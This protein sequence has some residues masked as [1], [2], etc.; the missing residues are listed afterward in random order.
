MSR[1]HRPRPARAPAVRPP[2]GARGLPRGALALRG[3]H[4]DVH[5]AARGARRASTAIASRRGSRSRSARRSSAMLADRAAAEPLPPPPRPPGRARRE[6]GAA[7]A[8]A[9]PRFHR[10]AEMYLAR[11]YRARAR[12]PRRVAAGPDRAP[13]APIASAGVIDLITSRGDARPPAAPRAPSPAAVRAQIEVAA[14]EYRRFFG[15]RAATASGCPSARTSPG[16]DAELARAGVRYFFV[17]THGIAHASPRPVYG[18]YAP[19]ACESGVAAFGRDPDSSKQVWSARRGLPRRSLVPRLLPRHRL[20]P[21]LRVRAPLPAADR[22]ARPHRASSTTGSPGRPTRRSPTSPTGPASAGRRR[23]RAHFVDARL[24]QVEWLGAHDGPRRRSSSA[25]TTPSSSATGGSRAR[26][27]SSVVLRR[28]GAT[29]GLTAPRRRATTSDAQPAVQRATPAASTWGMRRAT[30]RS[31]SAAGTTGYTG[32]CT[33]P[34]DRLHAPLPALP[35]R[36]RAHAARA[37]P[38]A[39]RAAPRAGERLGLHDVARDD[40]ASTPTRRT[41]DHLLRCQ[42]LCTEVERDAVDDLRLAALEDADNIF[43]TLD[44][45]VLHCNGALVSLGRFP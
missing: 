14:A 43:P 8:S 35:E 17:D 29:P 38:G 16:I 24:R 13:S 15:R 45:R 28:L 36:R 20:R 25:P 32:T 41:R 22:A 3:D 11:F 39:A 42:R 4:R 2:S 18:V 26:S 23:T 31:G 1:R 6:G 19:I 40:G 10:L 37:H 9:T 27:G 33:P 7:H 21:R 34:A 5:P 12:L 30:T 44:Y